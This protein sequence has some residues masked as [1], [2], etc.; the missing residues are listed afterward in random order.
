MWEGGGGGGG[1]CASR[2]R[3]DGCGDK[4]PHHICMVHVDAIVVERCGCQRRP[5]RW[6]DRLR[7]PPSQPA[8]AGSQRS[9]IRR[10]AHTDRSRR[11]SGPRCG[12]TC[13]EVAGRTRSRTACRG[14]GTSRYAGSPRTA[15]HTRGR[16][17]W[18][19]WHERILALTAAQQQQLAAAA[20]APCRCAAD[21]QPVG[22]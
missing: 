8:A 1:E 13:N 12:T 4:Q 16:T 20:A 15:A 6:S 5:Q 11:S 9:R 21:F 10:K 14:A 2:T 19:R 22:L 7:Q 3:A 17:V 18:K